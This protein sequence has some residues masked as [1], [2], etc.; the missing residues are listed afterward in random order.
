[1]NEYALM[2]NRVL[3]RMRSKVR[4]RQY[5]MTYHARKEMSED[6][7]TVYDVE[8]IILTGEILE[9]QRDRDTGESKYRIRG[10]TIA[11]ATV[12][13][14]AKISPTGKLVIITVYVV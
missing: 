13:V 8:R 6:G 2:F 10:E 4:R 3:H 12:E 5:V 7:F 1:M 9:R 14:I 11:R